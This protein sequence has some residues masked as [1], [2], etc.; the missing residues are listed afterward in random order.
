LYIRVS[1]TEQN[2]DRQK[3]LIEKYNADVVY[4]VKISGVKEKREELERLLND[5]ESGDIVIVESFS[6]IARNMKQLLSIVETFDEKNVSLISEKE[7]IKTNT[8][9]GKLM[10]H[11]FAALSQFERDLLIERTKEGLNS[12]KKRGVTFGRK[13]INKEIIDT[14]ME[15]YNTGNYTV[16]KI[17]KQLN[18][19]RATF[20][21]EKRE[22]MK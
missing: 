20:Y 4:E 22:R 15:L 2:T 12:A 3:E 21:R 7:D 16:D 6:R 5:V 18:I 8:A 14:A 19:S 10:F 9:S 13:K 11:I 1:K 17:C